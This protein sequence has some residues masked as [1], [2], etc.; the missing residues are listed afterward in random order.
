MRDGASQVAS[1]SATY[2]VGT[3][4]EPGA[5]RAYAAAVVGGRAFAQ[6]GCPHPSTNAHSPGFRL[7]AVDDHV[8]ALG[9]EVDTSSSELFAL[10]LD[11]VDL[12][13]E[14]VA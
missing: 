3:V 1:L 14:R 8:T 6:L 12:R 13:V 2:P 4:I 9:G 10:A 7:H 11:R 5:L